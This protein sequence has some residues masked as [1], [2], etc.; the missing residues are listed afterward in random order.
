[1]NL[2]RLTINNQSWG[3]ESV[4]P[5]SPVLIDRTGVFRVATTDPSRQ[6]IFLSNRLEGDFRVR[7][8]LHELSH[9]VLFAYGL[10]DAIHRYVN[11]RD[12]IMAEEWVCNFMADYGRTV[13]QAA[14]DTLGEDALPVVTGEMYR[15]IS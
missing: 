12:W 14:Y 10:T 11:P 13:F 9:V 3:V 2:N 7:V 8:L 15:L 1:M 4:S 6:M 5:D